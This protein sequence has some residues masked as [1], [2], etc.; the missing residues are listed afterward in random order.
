[1]P[2][3]NYCRSIS[4]FHSFYL[5]LQYQYL[6]TF[7]NFELPMQCCTNYC[8]VELTM[9]TFHRLVHSKKWN[10]EVN[11][12][13]YSIILSSIQLT[14]VLEQSYHYLKFRIIQESFNCQSTCKFYLIH[15]ILYYYYCAVDCTPY[16][17]YLP[18]YVHTNK[19]FLL[20]N[21]HLKNCISVI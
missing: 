6:S 1:V 16:W 20:G 7:W 18:Y 12:R 11:G 3:I 5:T 9:L 17:P 8:I 10:Y 15:T 4:F 14:V 2:F 21:G 19:Q 13:N